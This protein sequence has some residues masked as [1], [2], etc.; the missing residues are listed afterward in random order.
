MARKNDRLFL[1]GLA[2]FGEE[3][4]L[5]AFDLGDPGPLEGGAMEALPSVFFLVDVETDCFVKLA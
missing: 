4:M 5:L 1:G 3:V 2:N